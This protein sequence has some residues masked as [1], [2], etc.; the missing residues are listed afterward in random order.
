MASHIEPNHDKVS[1]LTK[2]PE[3]TKTIVEVI[4]EAKKLIAICVDKNALKPAGI[5]Q[6]FQAI[7]KAHKRG[8]TI[9][10]VTEVTK[11]NL[12]YC[13]E[14]L[15]V[16]QV[17]H[18]DG[19][20]GNFVVTDT[21]Y[22]GTIA[23]SDIQSISQL[24]YSNSKQIVEQQRF[25]FDSLFEKAI[26][27]IQRI[28]EIEDILLTERTRVVY[29]K[30]QILSTILAWQQSAQKHWNLCVDSAVPNFS[31]SDKIRNGYIDAKN[32]GVKIRYI[33]E[34]TND[35][36]E[37]CKEIMK[38]AEV[39]HLPGVIGNF[40]VSEKEYLGEAVSKDFFSHLVCSNKKE[41]VEQQN[42][43]FENLWN[44]AVPEADKVRQIEEGIEPEEIKILSNPV[45]IQKL[46]K[47]LLRTAMSEIGLIIS[48]P[49]ALLRQQEIGIIKLIKQASAERNVK[50]NLVI[51]KIDKSTQNQNESNTMRRGLLEVNDLPIEFRN[52]RVRRH[53][54]SI[55]QTSKIKSTILLADRQ[56]SLL[57]DLKDDLKRR[58][59]DAIG[60]ASYSN[61][62][63][64][65]QSYNFIFDTI[66]R[67]ADVYEQL[68]NKTIELERLTTIQNE[69]INVAAHELRTPTQAILGYADM[70][71]QSTERNRTYEV[72]IARNAS[73][74]Y[75]LSSDILDLARI[76]SQTF[77]LDMSNFDLNLE[78][79]NI[80][81]EV[82]ARREW[83]KVSDKVKLIFDPNESIVLFGDERRIGQVILN[84][85][86]NA[87]K[88]TEIGTINIRVE[89]SSQTNEAI[90]T[91]KDTGT[92]IDKEILPRLF[93]K[94]VSK[95]KSG[96]GLGLFITKAIVEA[97][98]GN[99]QGYNNSEGKGATFRFTIPLAG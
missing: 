90:V 12:Q 32:R 41:I 15:D 1:I 60:F 62:K 99:I 40:V 38:Y 51:P 36:L 76:E 67:Q 29:G 6:C 96:T 81:K 7:T 54:P 25:L 28:K 31:M 34:I 87:L 75:S 46:Y 78:V 58:F 65:T 30:E 86:N 17:N 77:K 11:E 20:R 10:Y 88:F 4:S 14:L 19:I 18:V 39:R 82:M 44:S 83:E 59:N 43:I 8:A 42:Y 61:S 93:M 63:S 37:Q 80:I 13:K 9:K 55:N 89:K 47:N 74:L 91:V 56:Y 53:L 95:S 94:F 79:E 33:T 22:L 48:T 84:L 27:A 73:R 57:I 24:I 71:A 69:F 3:I 49:N 50:V 97:H 98:G 2:T 92:G 21:H 5:D 16:A 85:I 26:P 68:E 72:A 64:R 66:W 35:N 70:L 23:L 45:E 52:I